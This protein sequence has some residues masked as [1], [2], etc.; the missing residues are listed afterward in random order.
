[1]SSTRIVWLFWWLYITEA[2]PRDVW[3][4]QRHIKDQ[5]VFASPKSEEERAYNRRRLRTKAR[6]QD[7]QRSRGVWQRKERG[8]TGW[9]T[10]LYLIDANGA[11][12]TKS[13]PGPFGFE[14]D[15]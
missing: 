12:L 8:L 5:V 13:A 1:M 3:Q 15:Q 4:M 7:S 6:N 11:S 10:C 2:H 14:P 9:P